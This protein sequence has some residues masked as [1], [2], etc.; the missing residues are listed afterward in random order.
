M[1]GKKYDT[2]KPLW[3]L[4]PY[5]EVA[6]VV[7]VLTYGANKYGPNNWQ[8]VLDGKNRYFAAA[9]RHI[10]AWER[11]EFVDDES[12]LPHLAHAAC[13]LLFIMWLDSRYPGVGY[14]K[15]EGKV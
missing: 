4:L 2:G 7:D 8:H 12:K 3:H 10:V 9:M 5:Q 14:P 11:G 13:C 15:E 1:E 6:K